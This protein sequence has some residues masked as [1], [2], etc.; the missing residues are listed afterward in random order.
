MNSYQAWS[1]PKYK[2]SKLY[3]KIDECFISY[4]FMLGK[5]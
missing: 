2:Y 5:K 1:I 4:S 3:L